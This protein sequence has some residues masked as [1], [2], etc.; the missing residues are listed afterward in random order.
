MCCFF[1]SR[2]VVFWIIIGGPGAGKGTQC[3]NLVRDFGFVH[4]S[5]KSLFENGLRRRGKKGE[6]DLKRIETLFFST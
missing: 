5:G 1:S 2:C 6:K 3:A 4:L